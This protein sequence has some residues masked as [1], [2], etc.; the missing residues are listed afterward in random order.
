VFPTG[1][2]HSLS[3]GQPR[4]NADDGYI[5]R[6]VM[7]AVS[8]PPPHR[9]RINTSRT[10]STT[11]TNLTRQTTHL[12][13]ALT[14]LTT[15]LTGLMTALTGLT[16]ATL[17]VRI[18]RLCQTHVNS[19]PTMPMIPNLSSLTAAT[20]LWIAHNLSKQPMYAQGARS[21]SVG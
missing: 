14:G 10:L 16:T 5:T 8:A 2:V 19:T 9:T 12:T 7:N 18:S 3:Y 6:S 21:P 17:A 11:G 20:H 4:S 13:T 1:S 15:A